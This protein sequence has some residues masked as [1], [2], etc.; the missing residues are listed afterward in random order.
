MLGQTP[1]DQKQH[2]ACP[3]DH[4]ALEDALRKSVK[5][6]GGPSN[7]GFDNQEWAAVVNRDGKVCAIAHSGEAVDDQWLASRAIAAEKANTA[8]A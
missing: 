4:N 6:T 8:N 7:G 1:N 5:P 2:V 3:I